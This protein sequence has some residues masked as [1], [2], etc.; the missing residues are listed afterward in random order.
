MANVTIKDLPARLHQR[1]KASA[2][3]N[4]RSLNSEVIT[5]LETAVEP[6]KVNVDEILAAARTV[7]SQVKRELTDQEI[8]RMKRQGRL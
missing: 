4:R 7:R 2:K 6:R 5:L 8:N 1:L 3:L